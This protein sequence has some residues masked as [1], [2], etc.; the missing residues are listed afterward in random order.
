[1]LR[2]RSSCS[3]PERWAPFGTLPTI[4]CNVPERWRTVSRRGVSFLSRDRRA[5]QGNLARAEA[6]SDECLGLCRDHGIAI[7]IPIA[8]RV[9][10]DALV[11]LGKPEEAWRQLE[12]DGL[13]GPLPE[14]FNFAHLM[15]TRTRLHMLSNSADDALADALEAGE[16]MR[17][18]G[19]T[20]A[21]ATRWRSDAAS[22]HEQPATTPKPSDSRVKTWSSRGGSARNARSDTRCGRWAS[23]A[24]ENPV[25]PSFGRA[26][27][28]CLLRITRSSWRRPG[29]NS[30]H[31]CAAPATAAR[32][33]SRCARP[34][35]PAWNR[36]QAGRQARAGRVGRNRC[37]APEP[38][39]SGVESLTRRSTASPSSP[40][41]A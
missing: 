31:R 29:S 5:R 26:N 7:G 10:V 25:S 32:R 41:T 19:L 34:L 30:G 22:A 1:M 17:R 4:A 13:A 27:R 6:M 9:T 18:C 2:S 24:A 16:R 33:A 11:A 39:E 20:G 28:F 36:R 37:P 35:T 12:H 38:G 3:K 8:A 23:R 15:E 40:P 21:A 14:G